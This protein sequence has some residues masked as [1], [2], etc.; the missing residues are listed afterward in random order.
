M[1]IYIP[2][3]DPSVFGNL[4][5]HPAVVRAMQH[6]LEEGTSY[7]YGTSYGYEKAREAVAE[8]FTTTTHPLTKDVSVV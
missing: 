4:P 6:V 8:Q 2:P 3:G 7:S 1:Y 5:P